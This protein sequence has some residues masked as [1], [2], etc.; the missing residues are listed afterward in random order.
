MDT[1]NKAVRMGLKTAFSYLGK[2]PDE[3]IPKL[4]KWTD[5]LAGDGENSFKKHRDVIRNVINDSD[6]NMHKLI[7]SLWDDID[8]HVFGKS[9]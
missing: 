6:C 8:S 7:W 1:S 3:N 9:L 2:N 4:M 5:R